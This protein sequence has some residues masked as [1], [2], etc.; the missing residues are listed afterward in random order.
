[1][2]E[3]GREA[4]LIDA[5]ESLTLRPE[6]RILSAGGGG[7]GLE[8]G[9]IEMGFDEGAGLVLDEAGIRVR[10]QGNEIALRGAHAD[11]VD[12]EAVLTRRGLGG[13]QCIAFEILAVG[14]QD[15]NLVVA[16]TAAQRGRRPREW[17]SRY[18]CRR[19]RWC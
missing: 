19:V 8:R 16:G 9:L 18:W 12:L 5:L 4:A 1:M 3:Q 10:R 14:D 6:R 15:E 2:L 7:D 13:N 11:G 17:R